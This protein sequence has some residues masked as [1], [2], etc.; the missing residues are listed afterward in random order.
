MPK[1]KGKGLNKGNRSSPYAT[2]QKAGP[3]QASPHYS[4]T[5]EKFPFSSGYSHSSPGYWNPN[6]SYGV[7]PSP[8]TTG[9]SYPAPYGP[10]PPSKQ[11]HPQDKLLE[12]TADTYGNLSWR[13]LPAEPINPLG[14]INYSCP[15]NWNWDVHTSEV[16]RIDGICIT[17]STNQQ[18]I[19]RDRAATLIRERAL[20]EMCKGLNSSANMVA[21]TLAHRQMQ[22]FSQPP[23]ELQHINEDLRDCMPPPNPQN[24]YYPSY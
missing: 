18:K 2:S 3:S 10:P 20:D 23:P 7:N 4:K 16:S 15:Q 5:Q 1:W 13:P 19:F 22:Q 14:M 11:V 6:P 8:S 12:E 21:S 17:N 24:Y 9:Y